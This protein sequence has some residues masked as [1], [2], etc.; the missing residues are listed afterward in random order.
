MTMGR[1]ANSTVYYTVYVRDILSCVKSNCLVDHEV[2]C[3]KYT[4][5]HSDDNRRGNYPITTLRGSVKK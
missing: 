5:V 3:T 4:Q 2:N 1:E